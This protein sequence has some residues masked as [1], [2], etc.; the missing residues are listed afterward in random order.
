MK[1]TTLVQTTFKHF[2]KSH[3]KEARKEV[4]WEARKRRKKWWGKGRAV[5]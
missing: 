1:T 4:G 3:R 5:E 2:F